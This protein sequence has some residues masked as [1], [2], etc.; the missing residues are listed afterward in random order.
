[1]KLVFNSCQYL[2]SIKIWCGG[3]FLSEREALDIVVKYSP[4]SLCELIFYHKYYVQSV[5]LPEELELFLISWTNRIPSK[6]LS[7]IIVKTNKNSL[8]VDANEENM[9]LIEKY[10]KLGIIKK[11]KV[12]NFEDELYGQ[13]YN[14]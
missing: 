9:N 2:E 8:N 1:M 7:L 6:S 3:K 14:E 12:T 13:L 4:K 10:I 5:L 11:F